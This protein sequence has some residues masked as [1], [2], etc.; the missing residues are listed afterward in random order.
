MSKQE[1]QTFEVAGYSDVE[2]GVAEAY[3]VIKQIF[4]DLGRDAPAHAVWADM[5]GDL[6]KIHYHTYVINLP[7]HYKKVEEEANEILKRTVTHLKKEFKS[8]TGKALKIT[9][10]K[11]LANHAVE[12]VSLNERYYYKAWCVY[13]LGDF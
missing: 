5:T 3:K 2:F 1:P 8:R 7:V 9:E 11:D 10:Q 4:A 6:L 12:K 13:S